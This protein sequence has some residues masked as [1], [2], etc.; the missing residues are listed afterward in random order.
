MLDNSP[1]LTPIID[2][3]E[4]EIMS[5][6]LAIQALRTAE[7]RMLIRQGLAS[8][9]D[10]SVLQDFHVSVLE[11]GYWM[12]AASALSDF[13]WILA[14]NKSGVPFY[15]SDHPVVLRVHG[16]EHGHRCVHVWQF[17][18]PGSELLFPLSPTAMF[19]AYD[20]NSWEGL[21]RVNGFSSPVE[22]TR[23]LVEGDNIAQ[24]GHSRRFVFCNQD[25]FDAARCFCL[26]HP[27]VRDPNRNRF[28][29]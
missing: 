11:S 3:N 12:E 22:F 5:V 16:H 27:V 10:D 18:Q 20:R 7:Q 14:V 2:K 15:T 6:F 9:M 26:E 19:Y 23:E 13:I 29:R 8:S 24:I 1:P 28:E 4:R 17:P 21:G 25:A